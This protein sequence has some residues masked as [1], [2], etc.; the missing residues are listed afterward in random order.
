MIR[1]SGFR[2]LLARGQNAGRLLYLFWLTMLVA[3]LNAQTPETIRKTSDT[4][5]PER[6]SASFAEVA[7]RVEPAVV[8][9]DTKGKMPE[10]TIRGDSESRSKDLEDFIR[11]N[12]PPRPTYAVGSGFIVDPSGYLITN[13]HVVQNAQ[14]ITVKLQSGEEFRAKMI[15]ADEE[16]DLAVLKI[17]TE[18]RL[19]YINFGDSDAARIGDWVLAIGSPFGLA[20][21]VTAGIISQTNRETPAGNV[22]QRFLQT[23]AAINR[24]NSGG[25][26]VDMD[27]NVIGV[28]SQI[29][30]STGD[31]NGIGFALPSNEAANVYR[32]IV[33][34]GKVKRGYLGVYLDS[35]EKEFAQVYG[36]SDAKGAIITLVRN[37]DGAAAKAGLRANDIIL[38]LD[39]NE[40]LDAQDL[41]AKVASTSPGRAIKIEFLREIGENLEARTVTVKLDERPSEEIDSGES[42]PPR[43]LPIKDGNNSLPFGLTL[44]S[45]SGQ[46]AADRNLKGRSGLMVVRIDPASFILEE[47]TSNGAPTLIRGDLIERINRKKVS[48]V[49]SFRSLVNKMRPGD[50]VVLHVSSYDRNSGMIM[51]RVVQFT[52]K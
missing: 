35:V 34:Y 51:P 47:R 6:L 30:T 1:V 46:D 29:A 14:R 32:Q 12:M 36:L 42:D 15:G 17:N 40:V 18:R 20:R 11:R 25:P 9:I 23:D 22:F 38:R 4:V 44:R 27:G 3:S 21:T 2:N 26:L 50:A 39:G 37:K 8:S 43:R 41:I 13:Y 31:Y 45:L 28:N 33:S 52:V 49:A 7:K 48:D 5:G 16:T 24:G 19:P 10:V